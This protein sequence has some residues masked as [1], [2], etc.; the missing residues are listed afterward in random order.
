[1]TQS[2]GEGKIAGPAHGP[3]DRLKAQE[4]GAGGDGLHQELIEL[5]NELRVVLPGVQVLFAF[6]LTIAFTDRFRA[7]N[8]VQEAAYTTSF[9][10]ATFALVLLTAPSAYH[11]IR[12]R[13]GDEEQLLRVSNRF[14]LAGLAGIAVSLVAAVF[15]VADLLHPGAIAVSIA[16]AAT[17]FIA[18]AWLELP[19]SRALRDGRYP[20]I[21]LSCAKD[22]ASRRETCICE[23]PIS[24][25]IS[26][27]VRLRKKRRYRIRRS[28][29]GRARS[30]S[31][32]PAHSSKIAKLSS[33]SGGSIPRPASS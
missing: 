13:H 23:M 31:A 14:A 10:A 19:L 15:L 24:A 1:V 25:A 16:A 18:V 2:L 29:S 8:G 32:T 27:C 33:S 21:S 9:F 12:F 30:A 28:R 5:L 4:E 17:V 11:R 3:R 7:L 22:R 20:A 26:D 6:L